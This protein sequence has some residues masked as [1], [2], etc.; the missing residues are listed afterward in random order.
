MEEDHYIGLD[1]TLED[2]GYHGGSL[3]SPVPVELWVNSKHPDFARVYH[4]G[5]A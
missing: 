4:T 3:E 2:L 5:L 1:D